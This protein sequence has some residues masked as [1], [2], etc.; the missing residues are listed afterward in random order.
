MM[1]IKY[2]DTVHVTAQNVHCNIHRV[3]AVDKQTSLIGR[4]WM[5]LFRL[6]PHFKL[7]HY[8]LYL[9]LRNCHVLNLSYRQIFCTIFYVYDVF[10]IH[11]CLLVDKVDPSLL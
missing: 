8:T 7:L 9:L 2:T 1:S 4:D 3:I 6:L 10:K 5:V 11:Q